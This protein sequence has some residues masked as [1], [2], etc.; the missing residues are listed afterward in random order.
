[1]QTSINSFS[2]TIKRILMI[3]GAKWSWDLACLVPVFCFLLLFSAKQRTLQ[4][5]VRTLFPSRVL[6]TFWKNTSA[7][8]GGWST[9][10][11]IHDIIQQ[12]M[13]GNLLARL[14][15]VILQVHTKFQLPTP[16]NKI[17][18]VFLIS[19]LQSRIRYHSASPELSSYVFI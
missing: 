16:K 6:Q 15:K 3:F 19:Y 17:Y 12:Y 4:E 10:W 18:R 1:M 14:Q 5:K 7:P 8:W 9:G 11:E 13:L 2:K